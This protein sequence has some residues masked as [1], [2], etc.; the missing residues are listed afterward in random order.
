MISYFKRSVS[1]C[2]DT[3]QLWERGA[4]WHQWEMSQLIYITCGGTHTGSLVSYKQE[5][6]TLAH[7]QWYSAC[8]PDMLIPFVCVRFP[9]IWLLCGYLI[10]D[11]LNHKSKRHTHKTLYWELLLSV[12]LQLCHLSWN[13]WCMG[14]SSHFFKLPWSCCVHGKW[15]NGRL[16]FKTPQPHVLQPNVKSLISRTPSDCITS[17]KSQVVKYT[18]WQINWS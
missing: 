12:C 3:R 14:D 10:Y 18:T 11:P 9:L 2:S 7:S 17:L 15:I 8:V 4:V 16:N 6:E 1:L 5:C 13:D